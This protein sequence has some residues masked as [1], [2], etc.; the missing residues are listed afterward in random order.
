MK[1]NSGNSDCPL[2]EREF[3]DLLARCADCRRLGTSAGFFRI[4]SGVI[5]RMRFIA[6]STQVVR[7]GV[8]DG[9]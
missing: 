4:F 1:Y 7:A 8:T 5:A 2:A 3:G 9:L 6:A